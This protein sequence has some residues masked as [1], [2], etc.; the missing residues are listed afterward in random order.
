[1]IRLREVS[2]EVS[3]SCVMPPG[4]F[5]VE[6]KSEIGRAD[7]ENPRNSFERT[8]SRKAKGDAETQK[9]DAAQSASIE[10]FHCL[11]IALNRRRLERFKRIDDNCRRRMLVN[12]IEVARCVPPK[13][14]MI[15]L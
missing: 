12:M 5:S 9:G 7:W 8:K 1:M 14:R 10:F 11:A 15:L 3:G 2:K 4:L 13:D 6:R